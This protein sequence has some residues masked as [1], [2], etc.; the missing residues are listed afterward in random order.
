M[1]DFVGHHQ[2]IDRAAF[3]ALIFSMYARFFG[4][5]QE[6]F[7]IAPDPRYLF[8]S[9]RH[10]EALAHLLYGLQSGGGFV[11]LT[12]EIGAGKTTVCR[13]F[14]EQVPPTCHVA[15]IFNPKLSSGELLQ[16]VCEEFGVT[17][18]QP[19]LKGQVDALN[20]FLLKAH[21]AGENSV[22][23]IDEAQ[24]LASDVLE[25]LRLLTN[26]ETHERKLLQIILIGQPELRSMLARPE[27]EQLA[28]RVIARFHL[29]ALAAS[30]TARYVQHRLAVAGLSGPMPF[31]ARALQRIHTLAGGVPRRINVLCDRAMLGAYAT[32]KSAIGDAIVDKAAKE[33]F[34]APARARGTAMMVTALT[35]ACTAAL[36]TLWLTRPAPTVV[37]VQAAT[38]ALRAAPVPAPQPPPAPPAP[39]PIPTPRPPSVK[40]EWP[41]QAGTE[42]QA[43]RELAVLWGSPIDL[44]TPCIKASVLACFR[45]RDISLA[46]IRQLDRPGLVMLTNEAGSKVPAQLLKLGST[47]ATVRIG[48]QAQTQTVTLAALA[49]AW[50]GEFATLWRAPPGPLQTWLLASLDQVAPGR[51]PLPAR[52]RDFQRAQGLPADGLPGALTQMQINRALGVD[53]PRLSGRS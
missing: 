5:Q 28:Q 15:Y 12:G 25:Q 17:P 24:S 2:R 36:A 45:G 37:A 38:A 26:L 27:L 50:R 48:G 18:Q 7:S 46:L 3:E 21:A 29:G 47:T 53:E 39:P 16:S 32:G 9:E 8:M 49:Q 41:E 14:L 10:R 33:V 19:G 23:V 35:F 20:A 51:T 43:W 6:P 11:L 31:S 30:E 22:L 44:A 4:L 34:E 13:C 42:A 1:G 52:V 40:I